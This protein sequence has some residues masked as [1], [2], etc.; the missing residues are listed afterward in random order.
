MHEHLSGQGCPAVQNKAAGEDSSKL[1][2]LTWHTG[3]APNGHDLRSCASLGFAWQLN[4]YHPTVIPQH[5]DYPPSHQYRIKQHVKPNPYGR[6]LKLADRTVCAVRRARPIM[7]VYAWGLHSGPESQ[8]LLHGERQGDEGEDALTLKTWL[9][10]RDWEVVHENLLRSP[11]AL[12]V[13]WVPE[14]YPWI[15]SMG[16]IHTAGQ[17]MYAVHTSNIIHTS[18]TRSLGEW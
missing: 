1:N 7:P 11:R 17:C 15:H 9:R 14:K 4:G 2:V 8:G 12:G 16:S 5:R 18:A 10:E 3:A 13:Y 6:T